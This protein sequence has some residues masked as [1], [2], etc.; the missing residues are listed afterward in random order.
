M[1]CFFVSK[2][3]KNNNHENVK[4]AS[5]FSAQHLLINKSLIEDL[6]HLAKIGPNDTVIDIGAGTGAITFPLAKKAATV[7]AIESDP[8]FVQKLISKMKEEGNIRVIH[9]AFLQ[10]TLP[11]RPFSV[12][13]NIPYSITT[14]ILGK[15]LDQPTIPMQ[16]AVLIVEKGAARRFTSLPI[17]NPRILKWRMWFHIRVE[18]TVSPSHFSPPPKVDSAVINISRKKNP[19]IL[20]QHHGRFMA[21]AAHALRYPQA[22]F[23]TAIADVFT[24]PQITKVVKALK[25][26]R[27]LPIGLLNERQW[28]ELF[29]AMLSYVDP[30]RWPKMSRSYRRK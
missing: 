23:Y 9:A 12:V 24:A 18:R 10:I 27:N 25:I 14:A 26:E 15:L 7:L 19:E 8:R 21:F 5:N 1:G 30:S 29:L 20:P 2:N 16:R 13:A 3:K 28:G 11:T 4:L 22:P 6:I 17:T